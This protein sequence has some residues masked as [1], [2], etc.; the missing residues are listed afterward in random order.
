[1]CGGSQRRI[2]IG[3]YQPGLSPRVRG[4]LGW[5]GGSAPLAR[6][7]PA[8]AGEAGRRG[9]WGVGGQVYPRVCG[10]STAK[11]AMAAAKQGLSPRVRGKPG[12]T[13]TR[14]RHSGSIPACAGEARWPG[15]PLNATRVYPRVCGGSR[16]KVFNH[17][18][19]CGLSPRVR[20]KLCV[21][22]RDFLGSRSIPACAGEACRASANTAGNQVY[23]RVCGGSEQA[24]GGFTA[25]VGLSPRV[26]GKPS[27][28]AH[29]SASRRSIP[30]CAGE[31]PT[32]N[33]AQVKLQV[34]PRVCGGSLMA[35]CWR[36]VSVGLS[37]RVRGKR[38]RGG[39]PLPS[40]RSIP[41]CAGEA[42]GGVHRN[43]RNAVYPRVCGGSV[44]A[45]DVV[46]LVLGL[47]PR[48]RGKRRHHQPHPAGIRSIPAC[49]GEAAPSATLAGRYAVYP[50]VCGGS[51]FVDSTSPAMRGLSPRVRGKLRYHRPA[52]AVFRSIPAC[53]GE[54]S[55][56]QW[57]IVR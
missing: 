30:A 56:M 40:L 19:D 3:A 38:Q 27:G 18:R 7:I 29:A 54:A 21:V 16:A 20:G 28:N 39:K 37:P 2:R 5:P 14:N 23:P 1:M 32:G 31:A 33:D 34:Y 26:R 50:R 47:S 12:P 6:S 52:A 46:A 42:A 25:K 13:G 15:R 22:M 51:A 48:V 10:G 45:A 36:G 43:T 17:I 24:V 53:A 49:A 44:I 11:G 4:K 41:A 8:C 55:S 35:A 9:G 57:R